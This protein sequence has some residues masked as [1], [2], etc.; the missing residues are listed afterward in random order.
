MKIMEHWWNDSDRRKDKY[1]E[2]N[3]VPTTTSTGLELNPVLCDRS[4]D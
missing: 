3:P 1:S 2:K 4:Y